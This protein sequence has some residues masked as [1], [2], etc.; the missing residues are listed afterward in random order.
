MNR[1]A[2]YNLPYQQSD[3]YYIPYEVTQRK[4]KRK[5]SSLSFSHCD[6]W[7]PKLGLSLATPPLSAEKFCSSFRCSVFNHS[8]MC[9][10]WKSEDEHRLV[11]YVI[12]ASNETIKGSDNQKRAMLDVAHIRPWNEKRNDTLHFDGGERRRKGE[13]RPANRRRKKERVESTTRSRIFAY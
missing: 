3:L 13:K 6:Q 11:R 10:A 1:L 5:W 4:K 7:Y 9:R 12:R 8:R 2:W